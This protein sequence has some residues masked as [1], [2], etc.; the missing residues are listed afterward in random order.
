MPTVLLQAMKQDPPADAKCRDKFLVQSVIISSDLE[1]NNVQSI[2]CFTGFPGPHVLVTCQE[3]N[4]DPSLVSQWE[5]VEKSAIQ[6][7]KIRVSFLAPGG[8]EPAGV[9][10]TP[11]K[12]QP[13][14]TNGVVS[15]SFS[16]ERSH[17]R[18]TSCSQPK[19]PQVEDTPPPA[20][21]SSPAEHR[22]TSSHA[23][24]SEVL[25]EAHE[26]Q[27]EVAAPVALEPA[28]E[29]TKPEVSLPKEQEGLRQRK[30]VP[31]A[32]EK[33]SVAEVATAVRPQGTEGVPI[34][35]VAILCLIS[36]LLAYF[37]F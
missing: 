31:V 6:E 22:P 30:A 29:E 4:T 2:V 28:H 21:Y 12:Q 9:A 5:S 8:G 32:S 24:P 19:S 26:E 11:L 20:A 34:Q 16:P 23:A 25:T 15:L 17:L 33:P 18:I 37:F 10:A 7:K 14:L 13:H 1:F 27:P 36:F 35:I 3:Q